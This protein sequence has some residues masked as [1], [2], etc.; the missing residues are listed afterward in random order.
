MT[1][2][3]TIAFP[4]SPA[5]GAQPLRVA[6]V[7]AF[8][9][10]G[11]QVFTEDDVISGGPAAAEFRNLAKRGPVW[12]DLN[13][14]TDVNQ[15]MQPWEPLEPDATDWTPINA[16]AEAA[17]VKLPL[18]G[19]SS[20]RLLLRHLPVV[21][22]YAVLHWLAL[23]AFPRGPAPLI[24]PLVGLVPADELETRDGVRREGF[25]VVLVRVNLAVVGDCLITIRL[26]DRLCTASRPDRSGVRIAAAEHYEPPNLTVFGRFLTSLDAPSAT[27]M[28]DA[29][30]SYLTATCST[31]AECARDRLRAVERHLIRASFASEGDHAVIPA[32]HAQILAIRATLEPID[33]ELLRLSQRLAEPNE[34]HPSVA[35]ARDRYRAAISQ[36]ESVEAEIRWASDA[37]AN[38]L[39]TV[40]L[41][42]QREEEQRRRSLEDQSTQR[43]QKLERIIAGLGTALVIAA[44]VPSLFGDDVKL[45]NRDRQGAF[46]G[47]VL[48]MLGAAGV[49]FWALVGLLDS[50]PSDDHDEEAG[51]RRAARG[52]MR[53]AAL[54]AA[55]LL[56]LAGIGVL[57]WFG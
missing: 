53:D 34:L 4:D 43:Q 10:G 15:W 42:E 27:D 7:T 33:E 44:L 45:P 26:T 11:A 30:A 24:M 2:S 17:G 12:L 35:R 41:L 3:S 38:Q 55:A 50:T 8:T 29:L 25:E 47:M 6:A 13:L 21:N 40:R 46:I 49:V 31:V 52:R 19:G 39:A 9:G 14:E 5:P 18:D 32:C 22:E 51:G 36:L 54:L 28:A 1:S 20:E 16:V 56:I 37:A 48:L 57:M 23:R